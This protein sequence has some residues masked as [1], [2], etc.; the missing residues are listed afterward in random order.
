M[1]KDEDQ[2]RRDTAL[3]GVGVTAAAIAADSPLGL[4]ALVPEV[5]RVAKLAWD[6]VNV[7]RADRFFR[8]VFG[9]DL[10][11]AERAEALRAGLR[12]PH[13]KEAVLQALRSAL[14]AVGE[15]AVEPLAKLVGEYRAADRA[16]DAYFRACCRVLQEVSSEEYPSVVALIHRI[17]ESDLLDE[18]SPSVS[19]TNGG[20]ENLRRLE[21]APRTGPFVVVLASGFAAQPPS[22]AVPGCNPA[23]IERVFHLLDRELLAR[24]HVLG[25][26]DEHESLTIRVGTARR[27]ARLL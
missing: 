8:E 11:G 6:A 15:H 23:H 1:K 19:V 20:S 2:A 27:L 3:A 9:G 4:L 7:H 13:V 26:G 14:D 22:I 18:V 17:A 5:V 24:R 12:K 25:R 21:G 16:P 10:S